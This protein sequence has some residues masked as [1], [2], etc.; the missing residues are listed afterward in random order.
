MNR[1]VNKRNHLGRCVFVV[2]SPSLLETSNIAEQKIREK[3]AGN[4]SV[5]IHQR[6]SQPRRLLQRVFRH[7]VD[8]RHDQVLSL[9]PGH[10][11]GDVIVVA[12]LGD[13]LVS[14]AKAGAPPTHK[15]R[16]IM[17]VWLS[18]VG[19]QI[20]PAQGNAAKRGAVQPVVAKGK[21]IDESWADGVCPVRCVVLVLG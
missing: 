10:L 18:N 21:A 7:D 15:N 1:V 19:S 2:F 4:I 20:F 5:E 16:G 13:V 3:C 14:P 17:R 12:L 6:I 11:I 9:A 8:A